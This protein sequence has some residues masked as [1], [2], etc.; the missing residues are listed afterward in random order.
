MNLFDDTQYDTLK[1]YVEEIV[2]RNVDNGYCVINVNADGVLET[3]VG[4]F[5]PIEEGEYLEM[6]GNFAVNAKFGE[7]FNVKECKIAKPE[8]KETIM[9]YLASGLFAGVGEVTAKNIVDLFGTAT[10]DV[11]ENAPNKLAN[12]KGVSLKKAM[13]IYEAYI[14]HK[15][16]QAT[17]VYL[18][19]YDISLNLALRIYKQYGEGTRRIIEK[20]PYQMVEDVD[21]VG[22]ITADKIAVKMGF[23]QFSRFRISSAISHV[24]Q[25]SAN[26]NGHTYLPRGEVV[27]EVCN[28]LRMNL[29]ECGYLVNGIILDCVVQGKIVIVNQGDTECIF[30]TRI[31]E[32]EFGIASCVINL[33]KYAKPIDLNV[34]VDIEQYQ[35]SHGITLH[36]G[37][38]NAIKN[39]VSYGVNVITGGPGTGKTTIINCIINILKKQGKKVALCAPTGRAS[40][41]L[42][43]ATGEDA[44]TIHRLLDLDFT[45]GKGHFN[46]NEDTRLQA[47]VVIVD[48]VS[49][50]DEYVFHALIRSVKKGG[51]LILVGD[52]D[53]LPSVGAG[54]VLADIISCGAVPINYLTRI[55]R[56]SDD[57]LIIENAHKVNSGIFPTIDN[58]SKDFFFDLQND[59]AIMLK[60]VIELT[61][62]RLPAFAGIT[63]KDIQ[64]LCPT[65]KGVLGV[66]NINVEM[67]KALN[68]PDKSKN[69]IRSGANIFREGDKIIHT[70]NNYQMEWYSDDGLSGSGVFNG[71]IGYIVA[72]DK[73]APSMKV[74][75]DD[76]KIATYRQENFDELTL[77]YAISIHKSQGSEFPA[78][79]ITA[80]G[81][82][83]YL[84]TRNLLY[85]AITRAKSLVVIEGSKES[86]AKMVSN[87]YTA[88]RNTLLAEFINQIISN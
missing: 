51:R 42:S 18:Q 47:D 60:N 73:S 78:V 88:K 71:D 16:Q 17:I 4:I 58:K 69:E 82:N 38:I 23:D 5:P 10:L 65:K 80:Y 37:Q 57:S 49:M 40:K 34:D 22:F 28:L 83:P 63:P 26:R 31:Y 39:C 35:K 45:S 6:K 9:R 53:Q 59:T 24:L 84:M 12:V 15:E 43:E 48:E 8:D 81:G 36:E 27:Y 3:A 25:E 32:N 61:T 85:T 13:A 19:S 66:E 29:D 30:L 56:Q 2:F 76:G 68:A 41:R 44:K 64:V 72:I 14:V 67:Q 7:Q 50:C 54:N 79:I 20:N 52:K 70:V 21:G 87:N 86:T 1:G 11:I 46:Y 62:K 33:L 75:F 77:A 74:E 55:Y